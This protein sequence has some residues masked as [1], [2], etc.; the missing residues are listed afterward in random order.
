[1]VVICKEAYFSDNT[2]IGFNINTLL[3]LK[4]RKYTIKEIDIDSFYVYGERN[5][6]IK[7]L[8]K[9]IA[10]ST[11]SFYKFFHDKIGAREFLLNELNI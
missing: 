6:I 4:G 2:D 5:S 10:G 7:F 3:F 11:Y 1:M 8:N 9:N